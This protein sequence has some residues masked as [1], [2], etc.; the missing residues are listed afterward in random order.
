M[1]GVEPEAQRIAE[2]AV[3]AIDTYGL[4]DANAE[5]LQFTLTSRRNPYYTQATSESW[6]DLRSNANI[7]M[8]MNAYEDPRR[9]LLLLEVGLRR[10]LCGRALGNRERAAD[11][12]R[13][14]LLPA[15]RGD[16]PRAGHVRRRELVPAGRRSAAGLGD[17]RHARE[18]LQHGR[19]DL[20]RAVG[21]LVLLRRLHRLDADAPTRLHRPRGEARP[22]ELRPGRLGEMGRR[23]TR[24]WSASSPRSGSPTT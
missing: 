18:P 22:A 16:G 4:I 11:D 19:E 8:Y 24:A 10:D 15:L 13:L 7:T 21:L 14:L 17:G 2:E 23:R 3:A 5:N 1:S 12:L 20:L 9:S 6:Q